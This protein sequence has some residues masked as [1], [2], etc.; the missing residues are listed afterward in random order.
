VLDVKLPHTEH[1]HG[2]APRVQF[3]PQTAHRNALL[4]ERGEFAADI[5]FHTSSAKV[6]DLAA[7]LTVG[8]R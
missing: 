1:L 8:L 7:P 4:F 5:K 6:S 2:R 3:R